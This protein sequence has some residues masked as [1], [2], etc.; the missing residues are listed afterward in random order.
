MYA[1]DLYRLGIL[2]LYNVEGIIL[3][4]I[5][6]WSCPCLWYFII[7]SDFKPFKELKKRI[8]SVIK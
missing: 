7:K 8:D 6:A 5:V 4:R 2:N 1:N 3:L